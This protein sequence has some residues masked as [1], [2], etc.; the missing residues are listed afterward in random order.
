[1]AV[2]VTLDIYSGLPNPSWELSEAQARDLRDLLAQERAPS[3]LLSPAKS[4]L[5]GYRGFIV[6]SYGDSSLPQALQVFDG[7]LDSNRLYA[8]SFLDDNSEV[9]SFL[10]QTAGDALRPQQQQFVA[11]EMAK[12]VS[13]GTANSNSLVAKN[14]LVVPPF[15]PGKW[16]NNPVVLQRNNCYNYANDKITNTFAQPGRGS[17]AQGPFPPD[18]G[19]TGAAAVRDG[20]VVTGAPAA[21]PAQGHFVA[22]V[23]WPGE[24]YHWYRLDSNGMWSHKRGGTQ[25]INIDASG[26]LINDPRTCNRGPYSVFCGFYHCIPERTRIS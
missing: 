20:Q 4:G 23:I 15:D 2:L 11:D 6:E 14:L 25:A 13:G 18:C 16:N 3:N 21:T 12:N 22:L 9:E 17:G 8:R 19:S 24:D 26:A 1:M 7:I 5:M 10:L